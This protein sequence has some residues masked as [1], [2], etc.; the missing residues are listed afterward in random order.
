MFAV[1]S[2][3]YSCSARYVS[4]TVTMRFDFQSGANILLTSKEHIKTQQLLKVK[5]K[6]NKWF[7]KDTLIDL[8]GGWYRH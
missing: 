4:F 3:E 5:C 8:L 6:P 7:I 2:L 1:S